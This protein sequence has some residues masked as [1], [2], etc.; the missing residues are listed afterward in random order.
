MPK[1]KSKIDPNDPGF[2]E[3]RAD[4]LAQIQALRE[5]EGRVR[6]RSEKSRV[7]FESRNQL[8][9]RDR[10]DLLLDR[11]APWLSCPPWLVM[12]PMT[13]MAA[14]TSLAPA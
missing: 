5:R 9:P 14:R 11:G 8:L 13:T 2:Q 10:L 1:I 7:R 4:M 6:A 12:K 3:N